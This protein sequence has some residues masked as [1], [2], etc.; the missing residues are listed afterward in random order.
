MPFTC[1]KPWFIKQDLRKP[2]AAD[3]SQMPL[4]VKFFSGNFHLEFLFL[5]K[6]GLTHLFLNS[7]QNYSPPF[8]LVPTSRERA[9]VELKRERLIQEQSNVKPKDSHCAALKICQV[10]EKTA[11]GTPAWGGGGRR[12]GG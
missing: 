11:Q 4:L 5:R 2:E 8:I 9:H 7:S 12:R 6:P 1:I 3:T 10:R